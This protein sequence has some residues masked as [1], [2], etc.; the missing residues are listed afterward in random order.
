MNYDDHLPAHFHVAYGGEFA[1]V[2]IDPFVIIGG[3]LSRNIR[4]MTEVDSEW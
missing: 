3:T 2:G 1:K 4:R